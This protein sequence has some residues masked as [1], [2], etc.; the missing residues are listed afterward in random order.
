MTRTT[1]NPVRAARRAALHT[2]RARIAAARLAFVTAIV[3]RRNGAAKTSL[4]AS[5]ALVTVTAYMTRLGADTETMRRYG[6]HAGKK[7]K[8][9]FIAATGR[10]PL[11]VWTVRNNMPIRVC[12]YPAIDPAL[13]AGLGAY[14]R[15]AHLVAA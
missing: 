8:A 15:T 3:T 5:G 4:L 7:V 9:A 6:S 11:Q 2:L 13:N 10:D 1:Y 12:A 14:N